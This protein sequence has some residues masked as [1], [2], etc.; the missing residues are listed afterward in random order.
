MTQLLS[1]SPSGCESL[2][3]INAGVYKGHKVIQ[4][5]T[6]TNCGA[7]IVFDIN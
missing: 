1:A 2:D 6:L 4:I 7:L 5:F 3:E